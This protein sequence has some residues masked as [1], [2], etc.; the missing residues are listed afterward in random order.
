MA[1]IEPTDEDTTTEYLDDTTDMEVT[2][3]TE[4][5]EDTE[6]EGKDEETVTEEET[7]KEEEDEDVVEYEDA[8]TKVRKKHGKKKLKS[9]ME[10]CMRE[11]WKCDVP[12][13]QLYMKT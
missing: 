6:R 4:G 7:I 13:W 10:R 11:K 5:T 2:E 8:S 1:E 12:L 3:D 9:W